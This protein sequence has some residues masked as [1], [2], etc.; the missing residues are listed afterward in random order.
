MGDMQRRATAIYVALFVLVGVG[1]YAMMNVAAA[2]TVSLSGP[3]YAAGDT[4]TV[5]DRAYTVES[6]SA[7][8]SEEGETNFQGK[9]TWNDTD[10]TFSTTLDNGTTVSPVEIIWD[11][12]SNRNTVTLSNGST[13]QFDGDEYVVDLDVTNESLILVDATNASMT[14]SVAVGDTVSLVA[15]NQ[16]VTEGTLTA[17]SADAATLVWGDPYEVVIENA[18]DPTEVTFV[19]SFDVDSRLQNDPAVYN[20]TVTI[21]GTEYVTYREDNRNVEL[22][23]YLPAPERKT[24]QENETVVYQDRE[25]QFGNITADAAPLLYTGTET[26]EITLTEGG[27]V[28]LAGQQYFA[29]FPGEGAVQLLP[30]SDAYSDYRTDLDAID[31]YHERMA[32]LWAVLI[33]SAL[34][35]V[36]LLST[37]YMPVRG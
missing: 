26:N 6:I 2:P 5:Q 37:A 29:H 23:T 21:E 19:Q 3:S 16:S 34:A 18:T 10:A 31:R 28:S 22:A 7:T 25:R 12:Q 17:V 20:Q 33:L 24:F 8:E 9:L 30:T 27:N 1:A 15:D 11:D 4:I 14:S 32:G 36:L 35:A 13:V